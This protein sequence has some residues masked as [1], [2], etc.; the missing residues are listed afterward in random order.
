MDDIIQRWAADLPAYART[1]PTPMTVTGV[2]DKPSDPPWKAEA[3][4]TLEPSERFEVIDQV[5]PSDD[6]KSVKF[7]E[8][9]VFGLLDA[10]VTCPG[11]PILKVKITLTRAVYDPIESTVLAFRVAGK[12]AGRQVCAAVE[13]AERQ[14]KERWRET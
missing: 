3:S 1:I 8:S 9:F 4:A 10:L 6:L 11:R 12:D 13:E 5:A 14:R 2:C 7:P